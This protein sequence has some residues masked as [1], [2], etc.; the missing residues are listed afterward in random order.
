MGNVGSSDFGAWH[1]PLC[2][3]ACDI[4]NRLNYSYL[5]FT[6]RTWNEKMHMKVSL[7][8]IYLF[9]WRTADL[10]QTLVDS[11]KW[12]WTVT[13]A[14]HHSSQL[15]S[16][17]DGLL[18]SNLYSRWRVVWESFERRMLMRGKPQAAVRMD[19]LVV[20]NVEWTRPSSLDHQSEQIQYFFV[21]LV[22]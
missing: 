13:F 8:F 17:A 11:V 1:K 20:W 21:C 16:C 14:T 2:V 18:I 12:F 6:K 5:P 4:S 15:M 10:T 22:F 9:I 19:P 7:I 3:C